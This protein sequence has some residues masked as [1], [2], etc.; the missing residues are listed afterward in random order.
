VIFDIRDKSGRDIRLT[1]ERWQHIA[2]EHPGIRID[3]IQ[4]ALIVP[5][6]IKMSVYDQ[7][8]RWYYRF[9]KERKRYLFVAVKYLNGHGFVIT[10]YFTR[11]L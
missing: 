3:W 7:S 11:T 1:E 6:I 2:Q 8:T 10:S 9:F 4:E 5:L